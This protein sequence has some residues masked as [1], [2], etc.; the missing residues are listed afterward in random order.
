[1]KMRASLAGLTAFVTVPLCF[2]AIVL[3]FAYHTGKAAPRQAVSGKSL[4]AAHEAAKPA[5]ANLDA[6]RTAAYGKLPMG[7]EENKG[8]TNSE[9]RFLSHGQGYELFLTSQ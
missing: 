8:Q 4:P 3:L 6:Q 1:M 5:S 7:F 9:V 2:T